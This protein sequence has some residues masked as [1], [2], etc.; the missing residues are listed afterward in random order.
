[1]QV[2][3]EEVRQA[4]LEKA[5]EE[6]YIN[7]FQKSSIRKI[8]KSAGTTIGNFYNYFK[9][10]EELFYSI[11]TPIYEKFVYFIKN[12]NKEHFNMYEAA[13]IYSKSFRQGIE[14]FLKVIDEDFQKILIILIDG[15][16]GTKYENIKLEIQSFLARH[17]EEHL[18]EAA[19]DIKGNLH[20]YFSNVVAVGF[21]EG[22][23]DILRT[24]YPRPEKEKLI[25]DYIIFFILGGTNFSR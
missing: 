14:N 7:G 10:K 15:S 16:K 23:L 2:L 9:S 8:V 3:K 12:H 19:Q 22:L 24:N 1:M 21:L 5:L 4:I 20:E 6:F 17:F 18:R 25:A 13:D 11:T